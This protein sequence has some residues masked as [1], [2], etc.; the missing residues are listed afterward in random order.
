MNT[1][2][3]TRKATPPFPQV[4]LQEALTAAFQ[5]YSAQ[6]GSL[7]PNEARFR[8]LVGAE[9]SV[10]ALP[11]LMNSLNAYD[12]TE[13]RPGG[14]ALTD[15][16][17]QLF[18]TEDYLVFKARLHDAAVFPVLLRELSQTYGDQPDSRKLNDDLKT[19]RITG[20]ERA[21]LVAVL[22]DNERL[23]GHDQ[24]CRELFGTFSDFRLRNAEPLPGAGIVAL[25]SWLKSQ[26]GRT[27]MLSVV[28][29]LFA[30]TLIYFATS[31]PPG[32]VGGDG[33][34][35]R[36]AVSGN[37][38][39][40]RVTAPVP[41]VSLPLLSRPVARTFP[42]GAAA[43]SPTAADLA[44]IGRPINRAYV[45]AATRPAPT[46]P[47][48][49]VGLPGTATP[50]AASQTAASQTLA[51]PATSV[52]VPPAP[53]PTLTAVVPAV[54][55]APPSALQA[56]NPPV[57]PPVGPPVTNGGAAETR[58]AGSTTPSAAPVA[59]TTVQS[60]GRQAP[61]STLTRGRELAGLF[62]GQRLTPL[63]NAFSPAA[64]AEWESFPAFQAY[65]AGGLK[66][67]GA[68]KTV[69]TE[70]VRRDKGVSYYTR[71]ATFELGP[72]KPWTLIIGLDAQDRVVEFN[73]VAA[74]VLPAQ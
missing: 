47:V 63:W 66:T 23:L 3:T 60:G 33:Q 6:Q 41:E 24:S 30:G 8:T 28:A 72:R 42:G 26:R 4:G 70:K 62:Y 56:P 73:V 34:V 27:A 67:F 16:A 19:R 15:R 13:S 36:G 46:V 11:R 29:A 32:Q 12:L 71:T 65:R 20:K 51:G 37:G 53:V 59:P 35:A 39:P 1:R 49:T 64:K 43:V 52:P 31:R 14:P 18:V 21:T 48:A 61:S 74:S 44:A 55:V 22:R 9:L 57:S 5:V 68:E 10:S 2:S 69:L 50:T 7:A 45:Q 40:R 25:R 17:V 54:T 38:T 58:M